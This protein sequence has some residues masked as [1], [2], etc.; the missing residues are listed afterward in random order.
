MPKKIPVKYY[1]AVGRRKLAVAR[2]RLYIIDKSGAINVNG[3]SIKKGEIVVNK[4]HVKADDYLEPLRL[5]END[6]RFA[7]SVSVKGGGK[8][9]QIEAIIHGLSRAIEKVDKD[10]YRNILKKAGLL[11]RDPRVKERR[12]VGRGG[13][14]RRK[15]QSPKR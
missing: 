6:Q 9:G 13:K 12:K 3:V 10:K 11:K 4:K 5:T 1:Q 8:N 15:K 2:V 7:I 14:A